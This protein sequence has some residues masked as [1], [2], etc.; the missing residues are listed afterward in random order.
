MK[1]KR[2][3]KK[4]TQTSIIINAFFILTTIITLYPLIY[5]LSVS[6][7]SG[8][9]F[10]RGEVVLFPIDMTFESYKYVL[11]DMRF[12]GSYVN[13]FIYVIFG[14]IFNMIITVL[15]AFPLSRSEFKLRNL[16]N[17]FLVLTM[18]LG[19]GMIPQY[20]NYK[21]LGMSNSRI[22]IILGFGLSAFNIILLRNYFENNIPKDLEEAAEIDGANLFQVLSNVYLPLSKSIIAT[23]TT[24]Y[25]VM[26]WNS[27]FWES[28]LLKDVNKIPLQV[29]IRKQLTALNEIMNSMDQEAIIGNGLISYETVFYA[30]L[31]CSLIPIIIGLPYLAK[32]FSKGVLSGSVK[33]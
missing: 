23:L 19:V 4:R 29:Y 16:L 26:R 18:W 32:Y 3:L 9:A 5:V 33:S 2:K 6:L 22:A 12:W 28:L 1:V 13:T 11:K 27:W 21:S 17:K 15:A 31:V 7:S 10:S 25:G 24:F 14:T 30:L 20:L 8:L